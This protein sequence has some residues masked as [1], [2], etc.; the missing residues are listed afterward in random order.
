MTLLRGRRDAKACAD[1][2][3]AAVS[4]PSRVVASCWRHLPAAATVKINHGTDCHSPKGTAARRDAP[5]ADAC[6]GE[7]DPLIT[8][9]TISVAYSRYPRFL[10]LRKS[11]WLRPSTK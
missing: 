4:L 11:R 10:F 7:P 6:N 9:L 2:V 3:L 8:W 5:A 1:A